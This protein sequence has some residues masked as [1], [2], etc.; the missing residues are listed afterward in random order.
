[1]KRV[2]LLLALQFFLVQA[3][4]AS[5]LPDEHEVTLTGVGDS[6]PSKPPATKHRPTAL[7]QAEVKALLAKRQHEKREFVCFTGPGRA[8]RLCRDMQDAIRAG[9]SVL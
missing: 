3:R 4:K 2:G 9:I 8:C 6:S 5:S 7:T 1:M